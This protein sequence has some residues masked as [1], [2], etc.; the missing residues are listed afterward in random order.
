[1]ANLSIYMVFG[2]ITLLGL[3]SV[4]IDYPERMV[5]YLKHMWLYFLFITITVAISPNIGVLVLAL[6]SFMGMREYFTLITI[7]P[8]DRIAVLGAFLTI[9]WMALALWMNWY[10]PFIILI[11]LYSFLGISFLVVSGGDKGDGTVF[12]IGIIVFGI[13]LFV[14]GNGHVGFLTFESTCLMVLV[15]ITICLV[16]SIAFLLSISSHRPVLKWY[17]TKYLIALPATVTTFLVF[18]PELSISRFEAVV[19]GTMVPVLVAAS[20]YIMIHVEKDLGI[21]ADYETLRRGRLINS[22]CPLIMTVPI[23]FQYQSIITQ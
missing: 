21:A 15:L 8:Q 23:I 14:V 18:C 16:D 6:I 13:L 9:P 19:I 7:R 11:L 5:A 20:R 12:S 17:V 3:S 22:S 4:F 2:I 10:H 1:M